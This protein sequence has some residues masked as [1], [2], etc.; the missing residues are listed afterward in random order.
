M[1]QY[2]QD[3]QAALQLLRRRLGP[4]LNHQKDSL[5]AGA[6][7]P[8]RLNPA[9]ISRATLT[10]RALGRVNSL[11]GF[12]DTALGWLA[13]TELNVPRRRQLLSRLTRPDLAGLPRLLVDDLGAN[14]SRGFGSLTIHR[15]L[16]L[17][18]L[19]TCLQ[20]RPSLLN[21]QNFVST[22]L[23]RLQPSDDSDWR[24]DRLVHT[25]YLQRLE[26]FTRRL[27]P[28][29]NS[30]KAHVLYRRLKLDRSGGV[31]DRQ[32]FLA[33]LKLPRQM[34]YVRAEVIRTL[35][36]RRHLANLGADY[37]SLTRMPAVGNDEPL[38]RA[39]LQHF[40]TNEGNYEPYRPYLSDTYL[41][42]VFAETKIMSGQGTR[43]VGRRC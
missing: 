30:L 43:S 15:R 21:E 7:L 33:Y 28:V 39:Y 27:D 3:P 19:E 32:R 22:Y 20:F 13:A 1:L 31:H 37:S 25:A 18:Q 4:Q 38:L 35:A 5:A 9:S 41:R 8:T 36:N 23:A 6:R 16:L 42:Q 40:F 29:H 24:N 11:A 14:G 12:E 10:R 2:A 17:S 26:N 34:F